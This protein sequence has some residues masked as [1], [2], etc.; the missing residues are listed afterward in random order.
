M[1]NQQTKLVGCL[2]QIGKVY[3]SIGIIFL[4]TVIFLI[5]FEVTVATYRGIRSI[6]TPDVCVGYATCAENRPT[7]PYYQD[8][9]WAEEFW[10][11]PRPSERFHPYSLWR[12][13]ANDDGYR[14]F[15]EAGFRVTPNGQCDDD[16]YHIFMFGGSTLW[17]QGSPDWGTIPAYLQNLFNE[18]DQVVC[19]HNMGQRAFHS[20]QEVVEL[21]NQ[22][23]LGARPDMVVFYD[24]VNEIY[25]TIETGEPWLPNVSFT[26]RLLWEDVPPLVK[27]ISATH[28]YSFL[29]KYFRSPNDS[30]PT[31]GYTDE[32]TDQII[33]DTVNT[34]LNNYQI[35]D[36]LSKHFDFEFYF[37]WQPTITLNK[38][39]TEIEAETVEIYIPRIG[40][41]YF[42]DNLEVINTVYQVVEA[43]AVDFDN[44]YYLGY[45]YED[46][47]E[48]LF[49]DLLHVVPKGNEIV[50]DEIF[51]I[52]N[53]SQ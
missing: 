2:V 33:Q 49:Y 53:S 6:I 48:L 5:G 21:T 50:A 51:R 12:T 23:Q 9:E 36:A 30:S 10:A 15:D 7:L 8:Q 31:I 37:F 46:Y 45:V 40:P 44:L 29:S 24:G 38:P 32:Q 39:L 17:G 43:R 28:T 47:S 41:L 25:N 35:V 16:T 4:T 14:T 42:E 20:T 34:Y 19:I 26:E 3:R 52:L 13:E 22:L 18:T 11:I 1:E 27:L